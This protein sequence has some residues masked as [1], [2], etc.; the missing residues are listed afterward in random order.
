MRRKRNF[1]R[2][3]NLEFQNTP[4]GQ[5]L[6]RIDLDIGRRKTQ[7]PAASVAMHNPID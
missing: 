3:K 5:N 2:R 1:I 6:G 4:G 7:T